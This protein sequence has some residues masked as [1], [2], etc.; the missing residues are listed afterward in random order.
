MP[1][2]GVGGDRSNF[3]L[4]TSYPIVSGRTGETHRGPRCSRQCAKQRRLHSPSPR[5]HPRSSSSRGNSRGRLSRRSGYPGSR[6]KTASRPQRRSRRRVGRGLRRRNGANDAD[7]DDD[8]DDDVIVGVKSVGGTS[9]LGLEIRDEIRVEIGENGTQRVQGGK[10]GRGKGGGEGKREGGGKT[11]VETEEDA[12]V[13]RTRRIARRKDD[14]S[15]L[16]LTRWRQ[17]LSAQQ[18]SPGLTLFTRQDTVI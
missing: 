7:D 18:D 9:E 1:I 12:V 5:L 13:Q 8:D 6:G 4:F 10:R 15:H 11:K 2:V 3:S 14:P 16:R 17:S